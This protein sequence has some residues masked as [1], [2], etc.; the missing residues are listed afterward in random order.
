LSAAEIDELR[1]ELAELRKQIKCVRCMTPP[2]PSPR[3]PGD[4]WSTDTRPL[5]TCGMGGD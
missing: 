3:W 2:P 5:H 1:T 4:P